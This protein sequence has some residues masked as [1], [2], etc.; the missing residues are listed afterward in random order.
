MC[1]GEHKL[2]VKSGNTT[3]HE[4]HGKDV[5]DV[6][7]SVIELDCTAFLVTKSLGNI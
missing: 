1:A 4:H 2:G 6:V 5:S 3:A 7:N